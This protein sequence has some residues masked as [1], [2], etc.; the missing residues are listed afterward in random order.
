MDENFDDMCRYCYSHSDTLKLCGKCKKRK[1]CSS[2]CQ[3]KDWTTHKVFCGKVGELGFDFEIKKAEGKGFGLFAKRD[4]EQ[5]EKIML[6]R[7]CLELKNREIPN[8]LSSIPHIPVTS[9]SIVTNLGAITNVDIFE[10]F[11]KLCSSEK[12]AYLKLLP[13]PNEEDKLIGI[14]RRNSM[15]TSG[16]VV[17]VLIFISRC[18][19]SCDANSFHCHHQE[20]NTTVIIAHKKISKGEEITFQ[21][22][23]PIIYRS[24][25]DRKVRLKELY[26]FDCNCQLCENTLAYAKTEKNLKKT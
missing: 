23:D 24:T 13:D 25:R 16:D 2:E 11:N 1:F 9:K 20:S 12:E 19:H 7:H 10:G 5:Y 14:F 22:L 26:F 4:F 18:N 17:M 15:G 21:Y 6:E 3:K 8:D